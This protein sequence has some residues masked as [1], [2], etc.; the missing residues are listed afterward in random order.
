MDARLNDEA[1]EYIWVTPQEALE[2]PIDYYTG[3]AI[4]KYLEGIGKEGESGISSGQI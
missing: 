4:R 3:V 1:Q 2:L